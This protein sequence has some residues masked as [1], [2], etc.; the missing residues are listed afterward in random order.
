MTSLCS[1]KGQ[2]NFAKT[3]KCHVTAHSVSDSH[4]AGMLQGEMQ[5][6]EAFSLAGYKLPGQ[7]SGEVFNRLL[8][9]RILVGHVHKKT[10]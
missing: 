3:T 7:L 5:C 10:A 8:N 9:L 1:C 6:V 2:L 4:T